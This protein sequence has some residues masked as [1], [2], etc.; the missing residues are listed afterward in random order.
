MALF[1]H[2]FRFGLSL[3]VSASPEKISRA[4]EIT[5]IAKFVDWVEIMAYNLR[6][7]W[8]KRTGCSTLTAGTEPT[9]PGAVFRWLENGMPAHKINLGMTM[10]GK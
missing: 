9:V 7:P 10:Y 1:F 5:K 3:S 6:G 8:R 2:F 4:Y